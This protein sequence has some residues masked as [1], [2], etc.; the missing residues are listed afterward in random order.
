MPF[1][2]DSHFLFCFLLAETQ[3]VLHKAQSRDIMIQRCV[4]Q[5]LNCRSGVQKVSCVHCAR[6]V[7]S[8]THRRDRCQE[9]LPSMFC[10]RAAE[11]SVVTRVSAHARCRGANRLTQ[12][13]HLLWRRIT[14]PCLLCRLHSRHAYKPGAQSVAFAGASSTKVHS[15]IAS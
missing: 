4:A 13:F 14:K 10:W 6:R 8:Q 7:I 3:S 1:L 2:R 15:R 11:R 9:S 5:Q 12:F